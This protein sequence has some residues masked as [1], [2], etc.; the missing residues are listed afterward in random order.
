MWTTGIQFQI[1]YEKM[2]RTE[3]Y[4]IVGISTV[5]ETIYPLA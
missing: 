3:P 1:I 4:R 5:S 2:H